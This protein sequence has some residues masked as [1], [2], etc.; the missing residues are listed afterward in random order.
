MRDEKSE[1]SRLQLLSDFAGEQ[2]EIRSQVKSVSQNERP[3]VWAF[4]FKT[5]PP[6]T[7]EI[8]VLSYFSCRLQK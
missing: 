3:L 4:F 2:F 8:S 5:T 7:L 6:R 1:N